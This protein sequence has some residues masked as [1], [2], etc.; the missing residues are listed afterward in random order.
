M[1]YNDA[2][3]TL[4]AAATGDQDGDAVTH[5]YFDIYNSAQLWNSGWRT[6]SCVET[7]S[8]GPYGYQW[9]VKVR[10]SRGLESDWSD[11]WHFTV[12]NPNLTITQLYFQDQD[13]QG[14]RVKIRACTEG[15]GGVGITMRVSVNT[16]S[17]GS[18]Q[19]EWR[20]IHELGVPCYNDIDAPIWTTLD[21][22][23]GPHLVKVE[24]HGS[25]TSWNGAAVRTETYHVRGD[26][27]PNAPDILAP[28]YNT[29]VNSQTVLI[30]WR[31]T[32][33]TSSYRLQA[34]TD[35]GFSTIILD[36]TLPAGASQYSHTFPA[37]LGRIYVRVTASGP[38]GSNMASTQFD[39]DVEPPV[40][41]IAALP[42]TTGQTT[43][44]V[45]WNGSDTQSGVHWYH[46][47][48]RRG[49]RA[50]SA[51][52]DWLANTTRTSEAFQGQPG[53]RYFFRV[54]AMDAAGNWEAWPP[55]A[56][57]TQILV[58]AEETAGNL[59]DLELLSLQ[60]F[61]LSSEE[62][63]VR[64][65]L[66]NDGAVAS[67]NN[68]T[69]DLYVDHLP[70]GAGDYGGSLQFWINDPIGPGQSVTLTTVIS[71][72]AA[73]AQS[74]AAGSESAATLYAQVDS[75]GVVAEDDDA[76][77]IFGDG[78]VLC[79]AAADPYEGDD[80]AGSAT[81]LPLSVAQA[82]NT[83]RPG[84]TDW[85][86]FVAAAGQRYRVRAGAQG[87][88]ADP[89]LVLY[90]PDGV[91]ELGANDDSPSGASAEIAWTAPQTA[92]YYLA[93]EHWNPNTGGCGTAYTIRVAEDYPV[94]L[95]LLP[96]Q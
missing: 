48:V 8:L 68:F 81:P 30:D 93:V 54:R 52:E 3:P 84:D 65:V 58:D 95:P 63:L 15:Q 1:T 14:E 46:V 17:N 13:P 79:T 70:A 59:P 39:I 11:T 5:Y 71:A 29:L 72:L 75:S 77:N 91:T 22:E 31:D 61:P 40:S 82:H 34:A 83:H 60:T 44:N 38:Y 19:G 74:V 62:S 28:R 47:Q 25:S 49:D 80:D 90:G 26:H 18:D 43:F 45:T 55:G 78:V 20:I 69:T 87:E 7:S 94:Y 89:Y 67:P 12:P 57:D 50:D 21:Y 16:A 73:G 32:L 64:L 41:A 33:R 66:R 42:A 56:G 23:G 88:V 76:N 92:S 10:D 96:A 85:F 24:A 37:G 6:G 27:R 2:T 4:C 86:V 51:W 36:Q 35:A 53:E 9:R